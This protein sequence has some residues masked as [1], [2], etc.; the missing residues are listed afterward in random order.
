MGSR[1]A[2]V[3][4]NI[5]LTEFEKQI[6]ENLIKR[7]TIKFYHRYVYDTLVL[8]KPHNIPDVLKPHNIQ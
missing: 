2:L 7:G 6:V 3:L 4:A 8:I 1:L 5:I